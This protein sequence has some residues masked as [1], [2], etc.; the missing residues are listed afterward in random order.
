VRKKTGKYS[1]E[2]EKSPLQINNNIIKNPKN[3]ANTVLN[4]RKIEP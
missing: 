3:I 4:S 2:E 1:T